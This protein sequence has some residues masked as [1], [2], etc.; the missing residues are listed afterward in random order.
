[1]SK[2]KWLLRR[3]VLG[4][5]L[6][7]IL[8]ALVGFAPPRQDDPI[9]M[10]I[11][12]GFDGNY[13]P[14]KW[15]PVR[16]T[17]R[18]S[19][20]NDIDGHIQ[21]RSQSPE[22]G[23][24]QIFGSPFF[25]RF[26]ETRTEYLYVTFETRQDAFLIELLDNEGQIIKSEEVEINPVRNRDLIYAVISET[27]Q[28]I[29]MTRRR[30]GSGNPIQV[31]WSPQ[32]L[33]DNAD[34]LRSLDVITFYSIGN[35]RLD[36]GQQRALYHWV[37][38]G[39]H[40]IIHGGAGTTWRF[41][42]DYLSDLLPAELQGSVTVESLEALGRFTGYPSDEL[43]PDGSA[44]YVLT[45]AIPN[46]DANVLLA[47]E[48]LPLITRQQ[49]G[50]GLVDFIAIDPVSNPMNRYNAVD[51]LWTTLMLSRPAQPSWAFDFENWESADNAI[52]I[53]TGFEL[54]SALQ[55]LGFLA[56]YVALIGPINYLVLQRIGR[57]ELAWFTIPL[58]ILVFT[59]VAYFTGFSLRGNAATVNHLAV[60][61]AAPDGEVTRV[62]GLI[63][64]FSPRRTTYDLGVNEDMTLR[65][66]PGLADVDT[67]IAEIPIVQEGD[68]RVIELPVDA[69]IV[70]TFAASGYAAGVNYSGQATW[71]LTDTR[72]VNL[73][74]NFRLPA[75][76]FMLE[77]AV[78]LAQNS[79]LPLGDVEAGEVVNFRFDSGFSVFL[80][81]P[82]QLS[83]GNRRDVESVGRIR[84]SFSTGSAFG[85]FVDAYSCG[86]L[87]SPTLAQVMYDQEYDCNDRSGS[88]SERISRR[89]AY[90]LQAINNEMG[91]SDGRGS[92]VY[93][94]GWVEDAPFKATLAG[95]EQENQ[96]ESLYIFELPVD[97]AIAQASQ[98]AMIPPGLS[99]W[100]LVDTEDYN[101]DRTPYNGLRVDRLNPL[102][103]RFAPTEAFQ[104]TRISR[105]ELLVVV[106]GSTSQASISLWNWEEGAFESFEIDPENNLIRI[107]A[108]EAYLGPFNE[109][110][111]G[112]APAE[113][114]EE[115]IIQTIE[116]YLY[117]R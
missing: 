51:A 5:L 47:V 70:A 91:T 41:A 59:I 69:G 98:E 35:A 45:R 60:V 29:E 57:R 68:F 58:V 113:N 83:L 54:P 115:V 77:D 19:S 93:V 48:D 82:T 84:S 76:A 15:T 112:I 16:V 53:V 39:G 95:T 73:T 28:Q 109:I 65:T 86:G 33:P 116:P 50:S 21:I 106:S 34:A 80:G 79:F 6:V 49:F 66:I 117:T 25:V 43:L 107:N 61:Q 74:G 24:E 36:D 12:A 7:G 85:T 23:R 13:R 20:T 88:D 37:Q 96:Y 22:T 4:F 102:I 89:R 11:R 94:L 63:G 64:V 87:Y 26:G 46:V 81:Q 108:P 90:L 27:D 72:N 9:E 110:K 78:V 103:Y 100:T 40:L 32:E 10:N 17:V 97:F 2:K 38:S 52:R 55:M 105:L 75:N 71:T 104:N 101:P 18:N 1:M 44:G 99:T 56:I 8:P 62:D 42:Q 31:N 92:N 111:V 30:I 3:L 67:G 14:N 114:R